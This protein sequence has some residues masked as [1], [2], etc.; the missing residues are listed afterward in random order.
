M[1]V[2]LALDPVRRLHRDVTIDDA[3]HWGRRGLHHR[4]VERKE[5]QKHGFNNEDL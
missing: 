5:R 2:V 3:N 4:A 1:I